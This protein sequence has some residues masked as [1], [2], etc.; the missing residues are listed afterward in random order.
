MQR[1][2][3]P[4]AAAG[5]EMGSR[6]PRSAARVIGGE[7]LHLGAHLQRL[8][9]SAAA[10][11]WNGA[12]L[13]AEFPRLA[14]WVRK[15]SA[16]KAMALR[17]H[18]RETQLR[19]AL[20]AI[21]ATASPYLLLPR[22]HPLGHP[23]DEPLAPHKGLT[24]T[25]GAEL[26]GPAKVAGASDAILYWPDGVLVETAIASI[27][28]ARDGELWVP[29]PEGRIASLAERL[30]LPPWAAARGWRCRVRPFTLA[31]A[32]EGQLLCFNALRGVWP[33]DVLEA[34]R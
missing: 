9:G 10:L 16:A 2:F 3:G 1:I 6:L 29:P 27:G 12:W 32:A 17:L 34:G 28:L 24:G 21:P 26:L 23:G 11:G 22:P 14:D 19:A 13:E 8:Q 31:D 20:E 7:I 4:G 33:A 5:F 18:L 15:R 25:W 30:D